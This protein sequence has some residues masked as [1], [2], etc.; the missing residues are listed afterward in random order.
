MTRFFFETALLPEG[1]RSN[2]LV[3]SDAHGLI[4]NV[5]PDGSETGGSETDGGETVS[6]ICIPGM[7]NL[8]SH[9][10][11]RAMAGLAERAGDTEDSFWTWREV[12]YGFVA[13]VG[14]DE[15]EA[16]AAQLY[17]EMLKA[18]YTSVA[19]FHYLHH[20]PD[21]APYDNPSEMS[22]RTIEAARHAGIAIT[23][24]PVLYA[25]GGFGAAPP[26]ADQVRFINDG[27]HFSRIISEL[28]AQYKDVSGV[29]IGMA[30]HSLRAI[31]EELLK[32]TIS[33]LDTLD[34]DAPIHIHIAEQTK[35][36]DDCIAWSGARPVAWLLD[37]FDVSAR[38]CL[39][40]ATHM[41][42]DE[43]KCLAASSAVAGLS[44]TTEANLGDG[45]F[46][47]RAYLDTGGRIGIGSDSNISIDPTEE[48]RLLEY[49]QRLSTKR[50]NVLADAPGA[51]T[52]RSLFDRAGHGGAQALGITAGRIAPGARADFV[53]LDENHPSLAGRRGDAILDSWIFANAGSPVRHV[54]VGGRKVVS[55]GI[56]HDQERI[57]RSYGHAIS[58]LQGG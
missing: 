31:S 41:D 2:V 26:T 22:A 42:A 56:H 6:G 20:G 13:R 35:E 51:S 44:P 40:H 1:W 8:H 19:E 39:I 24:L 36:V 15:A 53:I 38:W 45:I 46:P 27:E 25:H 33:A 11:Q 37:H 30:P 50:R 21:G 55:N 49:A 52:G 12:M 47:A 57:A 9:A 4:T 48:L 54:Y 7:P 10:F 17:V 29:S 3:E 23:H 18:G 5:T 34:P 43:L 16:I 14:P 58:R 28:H 32:D